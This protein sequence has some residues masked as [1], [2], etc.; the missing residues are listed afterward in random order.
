MPY[1]TNKNINIIDAKCFLPQN[2]LSDK[3]YFCS[4]NVTCLQ[5][6]KD[7]QAIGPTP[8]TL[9]QSHCFRLN[10]LVYHRIP[11]KEMSDFIKIMH[12]RLSD[13]C[14]HGPDSLFSL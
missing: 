12:L 10:D 3:T 14:F 11:S 8:R 9:K 7:F 4:K 13:D 5:N 1:S 6:P 2:V